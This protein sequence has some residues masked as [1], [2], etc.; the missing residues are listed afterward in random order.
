ML[1]AF[2]KVF[3]GELVVDGDTLEVAVKTVSHKSEKERKNF[4]QEM[5]IMSK[6]VHPNV[7]RLY[8]LIPHGQLQPF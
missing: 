6:I 4:R 7:V 8:G 5:V 1:G 3:R 2:G